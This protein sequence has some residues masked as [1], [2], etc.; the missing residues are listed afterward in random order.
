[1]ADNVPVP[2]GTKQL[3]TKEI[4]TDIHVPLS[5]PIMNSGGNVDLQTN[6]TGATFNA[7][8]SQACSQLTLVNDT[9][10]KLEFRQGGSGVA[11]PVFD[12][13]SFTVFGI[14]NANEISVRRKDQSS[15]QVTVAARWE[16]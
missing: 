5:T 13:T 4:S 6:A 7:F 2:G 15:T 1:M 16:A 12:Q 3:R 14:A 9:G 10:T 11:V 8:G